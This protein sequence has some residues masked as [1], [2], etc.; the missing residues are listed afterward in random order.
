M[1]VSDADEAGTQ[2]TLM[3]NAGVLRFWTAYP[4]TVEEYQPTPFP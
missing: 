1:S 2:E 4:P 3:G